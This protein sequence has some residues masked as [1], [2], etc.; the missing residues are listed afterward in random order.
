MEASNPFIDGFVV[1]DSSLSGTSGADPGGNRFC[2]WAFVS[3]IFGCWMCSWAAASPEVVGA[4]PGGQLLLICDDDDDVDE[5]SIGQDQVIRLRGTRWWSRRADRA[6]R[7]GADLVLL[8]T[9]MSLFCP[10]R[11]GIGFRCKISF[12]KSKCRQEGHNPL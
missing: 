4:G 1:V 6:M 10:K 2:P 8:L 12:E 11:E 9:M 5:P 7:M 3:T